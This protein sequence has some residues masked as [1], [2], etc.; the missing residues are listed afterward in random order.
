MRAKVAADG[1]GFIWVNTFFPLLFWAV[2]SCRRRFMQHRPARHKTIDCR[3]FSQ[4]NNFQVSYYNC[5]G[6]SLTKA[7]FMPDN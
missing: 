1:R 5:A 3:S 4:I 7:F 6:L 2:V